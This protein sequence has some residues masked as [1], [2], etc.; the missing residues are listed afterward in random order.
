M[1]KPNN[2]IISYE[3]FQRGYDFNFTRWIKQDYSGN[4]YLSWSIVLRILKE[5]HPTLVV[6]SN[7][8]DV[9]SAGEPDKVSILLKVRLRDLTNNAVSSELCY[10]IMGSGKANPAIIN[11]NSREY[12]DNLMRAYVK[13]IAI[14][15][16]IGYRLFTKELV[17]VKLP[18]KTK[19]K[20]HPVFN[21]L[22]KISEL[23]DA[24]MVE[25]GALPHDWISP[26]FSHSLEELR[27]KYRILANHL[28]GQRDLEPQKPEVATL[29]KSIYHIY[30]GFEMPP[31]CQSEQDF[32]DWAV[33]FANLTETQAKEDFVEISL[34]H[35]EDIWFKYFEYII[36]EYVPDE[37]LVEA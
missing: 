18:G 31:N 37:E 36:D 21:A 8:Y 27:S 25:F 29:S 33:V 15:T 22:R 28:K 14:N 12:Q 6:E 2:L 32:I 16:G 17:D 11:P 4:E 30:K 23:E 3:E 5:M 24:I 26:G 19:S 20:D 7:G 13:C 9:F 34:Q 35:P 1:E 10:P